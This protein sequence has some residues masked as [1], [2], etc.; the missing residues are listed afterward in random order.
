MQKPKY[1]GNYNCRQYECGYSLEIIANFTDIV[2]CNNKAFVYILFLQL[3][4]KSKQQ[5]K[6]RFPFSDTES[7]SPNG[8]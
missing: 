5:K 8:P 2:W 4:T 1:R 3:L 6:D 7:W